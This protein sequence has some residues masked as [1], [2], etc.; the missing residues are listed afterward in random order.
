MEHSQQCLPFSYLINAPYHFAYT[1]FFILDSSNHF[2]ATKHML[3]AEQLDMLA[4]K[5]VAGSPACF[6]ITAYHSH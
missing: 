4:R 5:T 1:D 6:L 2:V 3:S